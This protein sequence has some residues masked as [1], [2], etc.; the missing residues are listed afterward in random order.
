M[1]KAAENI[2]LIWHPWSGTL[3]Y[4]E[5]NNS[6]VTDEYRKIIEN[7]RSGGWG[8]LDESSSFCEARDTLLGCDGYYGDMCDLIY[9]AQ[10]ANI[11]VMIQN[12]DV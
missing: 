3:K 1:F 7:Y 8:E 9:E 4:L 6:D 11:P 5:I 10:N 12:I 2:R